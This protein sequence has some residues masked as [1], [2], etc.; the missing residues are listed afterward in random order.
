MDLVCGLREGSTA[1]SEVSAVPSD[2]GSG[3]VGAVYDQTAEVGV[4]EVF[5][6]WLKSEDVE[7]VFQMAF[8]GRMR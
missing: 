3:G 5:S 4:V 7:R 6:S 2:V 8:C 1:R